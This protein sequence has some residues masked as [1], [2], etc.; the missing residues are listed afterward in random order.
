M[1]RFTSYIVSL[2]MVV[3]NQAV[4][5]TGEEH[6]T[7][8][9]SAF[10]SVIREISLPGSDSGYSLNCGSVD[11]YHSQLIENGRSFGSLVAELAKD[12]FTK[13]RFHARGQTVMEQL[14]LLPRTV[15]DDIWQEAH[16]SDSLIFSSNEHF[17]A[18]ATSNMDN[19]IT[20][21]LAYH[22]VAIQFAA[23][24]FSPKL[25][26]VICLRSALMWE[27][28]AQGYLADCFSSGHMV[29]YWE[30]PLAALHRRN[31][32]EAHD[33]HSMQ[34]IFVINAKGDVWQAFG[35][36]ILFWNDPSYHHLV[37]ACQA[38]LREVL[39]AFYLGQ[40]CQL[41]PELKD[42]LVQNGQQLPAG[43]LV[44]KWL[45][46][47]VIELYDTPQPPTLLPSLMHLPM[48]ITATWSRRIDSANSENLSRR[49]HYPQFNTAGNNDTTLIGLDVNFLYH[50]SEV[51]G[52]M[53]PQPFQ[54][55][56]PVLPQSLIRLDP[57]WASVQFVQ[58]L[59]HTPSYKG[60]LL[61]GGYQGVFRNEQSQPI[62][63]IGK[64]LLEDAL[65][66]KNVDVRMQCHFNAGL[67]QEDVIATPVGGT[68]IN[69]ILSKLASLLKG[70]RVEGGPALMLGE[71]PS[72]GFA[73]ALGLT[74]NSIPMGFTY[75]AASFE[76]IYFGYTPE[77]DI[78][79]IG[80]RVI[81][82]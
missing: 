33:Q 22:L 45:H 16:A 71:D 38:S 76:I 52:W 68:L 77:N 7:L 59:Y 61:F 66:I 54:A 18:K 63:G 10:F 69:P 31:L 73:F 19:V 67:L 50:L 9:D 46:L 82:H 41:P 34:G 56:P 12:D 30:D 15:I 2:L 23:N 39:I 28:L 13:C 36:G 27:A 8:A 44:E 24:D 32:H 42:W 47:P 40:N 26:A 62:I 17:R 58:D 49:H 25:D 55:Q 78:H 5:F 37:E 79:G 1:K 81:L 14:Q 20:R 65:L 53:I 72:F 51:P 48:P 74:S 29:L 11:I 80:L 21:Y 3:T 64:G 57:N 6:Q 35:D 4:A 43:E 75:A 60:T 70:I